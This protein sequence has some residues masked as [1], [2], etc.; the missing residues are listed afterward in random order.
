LAD[1]TMADDLAVE[2]FEDVP[3]LAAELERVTAALRT[4][5]DLP[6]DHDLMQNAVAKAVYTIADAALAGGARAA[7]EGE[8]LLEQ[9][10]VLSEVERENMLALYRWMV[11][12]GDEPD[13]P[14]AGPPLA[15]PD[16]ERSWF[17]SE[18]LERFLELRVPGRLSDQQPVAVT[19]DDLAGVEAA[20]HDHAERTDARR[21]QELRTD[22]ARA[23]AALRQIRDYVLLEYQEGDKDFQLALLAI[24]ALDETTDV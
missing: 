9:V 21:E 12:G 2:Y 22:L 8:Q 11:G 20:A 23:R 6:S 18:E 3:W 19:D 10:G 16:D 1:A 4:I 7:Q 24:T 15:G 14:V 5:R 17:R 13:V